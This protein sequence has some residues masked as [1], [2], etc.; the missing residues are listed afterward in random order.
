[1]ATRLTVPPKVLAAAE[2]GDSKALEAWLH[3]LRH[4]RVAGVD[5]VGVG[6]IAGPLVAVAVVLYPPAA[7]GEWPQACRPGDQFDLTGVRDSKV[8]SAAARAAV[9]ARLP[10]PTDVVMSA[11]VLL[12]RMAHWALL[13]DPIGGVVQPDIELRS[14]DLGGEIARRA[15]GPAAGVEYAIGVAPPA[16]VDH[17]GPKIALAAARATAVRALP[18]GLPEAMLVDGELPRGKTMIE[19]PAGIAAVAYV[20]RGD[21]LAG[22]VSVASIIARETRDE[23]MAEA[24]SCWP[25]YGFGDTGGHPG[26][27]HLAALAARGPCPIHRRSCKPVKKVLAEKG[28]PCAEEK[29]GNRDSDAGKKQGKGG[30]VAR[31]KRGRFEG[32]LSARKREGGNAAA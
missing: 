28:E 3:G 19:V 4:H 30:S 6:N 17:L 11:P 12:T 5:E 31:G 29:K 21:R 18:S 2:A 1:M 15:G 23:L 13:A 22:A 24:E 20:P 32:E 7:K 10:P 25:G 8:M 16:V 26:V 9:M 14:A 27:A